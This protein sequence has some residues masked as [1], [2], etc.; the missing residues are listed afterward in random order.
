MKKIEL[1]EVEKLVLNEKMIAVVNKWQK[2]HSQQTTQTPVE[3]VADI[4]NE[5]DV[6][7]K[8]VVV[9][10]NV[11]VFSV[12]TSFSN[13][14]K[15]NPKS[16]TLVTDV[17]ALNGK[18]NVIYVESLKE[19]NL[20]KKFDVAILNPPYS[21]GKNKQLGWQIFKQI[22]ANYRALIVSTINVKKQK[23]NN[24]QKLG[25]YKSY[26]V[27]KYFNVQLSSI[28]LYLFDNTKNVDISVIDQLKRTTSRTAPSASILSL[29]RTGMR[30][31]NGWKCIDG[32]IS[33]I[34]PYAN[35]SVGVINMAPSTEYR[36]VWF[37]HTT[38]GY[39]RLEDIVNDDL[40]HGKWRVV[41]GNNGNPGKF[42]NSII[43]GPDDIVTTRC[44]QWVVNTENDALLLQ[45]YL[46]DDINV[47]NT[48][49]EVKDTMAMS[50]YPMSMIELPN[51]L[52]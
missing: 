48:L 51:F 35:T 18:P 1:S 34:L 23:S 52:K 8:T 3:I 24:L 41:Q 36:T 5:I 15:I 44:R 29:F 10:A 28:S 4:L 27:S 49:L 32:K 30:K 25:L 7:N 37:S 31:I 20:N 2:F 14:G 45:R 16:L 38:A 19:I 43:V 47:S 9:V 42:G 13:L 12:L 50:N 40:G 11:D 26:P 6:D 21:A 39:V 33:D 17:K 22:D 46:S